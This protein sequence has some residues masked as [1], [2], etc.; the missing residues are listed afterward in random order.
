MPIQIMNNARY[1]QHKFY[2]NVGI[3]NANVAMYS[4]FSE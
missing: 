3:V 2:N 1:E 4:S